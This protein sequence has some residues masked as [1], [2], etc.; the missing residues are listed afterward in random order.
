MVGACALLAWLLVAPDVRALLTFAPAAA[1]LWTRP[2]TFRSSPAAGVEDSLAGAAVVTM[3]ILSDPELALAASAI[4]AV[5]LGWT[6]R[7]AGPAAAV[8][9]LRRLAQAGAGVAVVGVAGT[10]GDVGAPLAFVAGAASA[11][12][13]VA[14]RPL[15]ALRRP[16]CDWAAP[17]AVSSALVVLVVATWQQTPVVFVALV[18]LTAAILG[19]ATAARDADRSRAALRTVAELMP[20][21]TGPN[22]EVAVEQSLVATARQLLGCDDAALSDAP[23]LHA[24]AISAS[25]DIGGERRW[26]VVNGT[27]RHFTDE[28]RRLLETIA[29]TGAGLLVAAR[30]TADVAHAAEHDTLT[31]AP[32][33]RAF[34]DRLDDA[35]ASGDLYA[36]AFVDLDG[37]KKVND[38]FG[39]AVGDEVLI[40]T[41]TRLRSAV[42]S[43]DMVARLGGDEF[44]VLL[45]PLATAEECS[46]HAERLM[47]ALAPPWRCSVGDVAITASIGM[48]VV[49][50]D[51]AVTLE[52]ADAAMYEAKSAGK[53]AWR[54]AAA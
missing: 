1:V 10:S 18:V 47:D 9:A 12:H 20:F 26:L 21:A 5:V 42:R 16:T 32:N 50:G 29:A 11:A 24:E 35:S 14:G 33:R 6:E 22:P 54:M 3:A 44:C 40:L 27:D 49:A 15:A 31:G 30:R 51:V 23:A 39:H 46:R 25:L 19:S 4:A 37:F 48:S 17:V 8:R 45:G 28:D 52:M 43:T 36:V 34:T 7:R 38:E 41:Y 13:L 2:V 53:N